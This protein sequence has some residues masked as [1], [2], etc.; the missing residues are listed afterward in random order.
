MSRLTRSLLALITLPLVAAVADAQSCEVN[1]AASCTVGGDA[2]HSI[3]ITIHTA[4]R[5][6]TP[7]TS[8]TMPVPPTSG[9]SVNPF[10]GTQLAVPFLIRANRSYALTVLS[11]SATWT[12]SGVGARANKPRADLQFSGTSGSGFADMTGTPT[13]FGSGTAADTDVVTKFLYLRVRYT[14]NLDTPGGY[15]LP[16]TVAITAP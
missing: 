9:L 13:Q 2:A 15:T 10:F 4:V 11:A 1:N 3:T 6:S 16:I 5:L 12:A 14:W 7:S 8:L